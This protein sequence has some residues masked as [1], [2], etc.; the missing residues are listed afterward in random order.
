MRLVRQKVIVPR[1]SII[2]RQTSAVAM[3][4]KGGRFPLTIACAPHFGALKI[5]LISLEH[6][7]TTRQQAI[8]GKGIITFKQNSCLKFSPFFAKLH[9]VDK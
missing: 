4:R 7:L 2:Y 9:A 1:F 6:H 3:G 5:R 8:M